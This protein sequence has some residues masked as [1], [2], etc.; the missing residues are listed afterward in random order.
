MLNQKDFLEARILIV[1]DRQANVLLL[2]SLL[3]D[4]GYLHLMSTQD[5]TEVCDLHQIHRFDLIV[6]DIQMPVMDGFEVMAALKKM[7]TDGDYTPILAMTVQSSH[8][9]KALASGA[10]DFIVKPFEL[11]EVKARIHNMLEVSLLYQKLKDS[12]AV[13]SS[14]ALHDILTKLPN[15]RLLM[16]RLVHAIEVS[17]LTHSHCALMF[18][19]ID[20][21]KQINDTLGHDVGDLL[22]QQVGDRLL[23]CVREGDSVARFGGDEF[24]VLLE[25]LSHDACEASE[26]AQ[27]IAQKMRVS[28]GKTFYLNGHTYDTSISIGVVIF[29]GDQEPIGAILKKADLAMYQAKLEGRN[30]VR[31]FDGAMQMELHSHDALTNDMHRGLELQEFMLFY[32]VQV[33]ELGVPIGAEALMRWKHPHRGLMV[34]A[35]FMP[36]AE[37]TCMILSLGQWVLETACQQLRAWAKNPKTENW[38]MAINVSDCQFAKSDFVTNVT[39]ALQ[40]TGANPHRLMLELTESILKNNVQDVIAKMNALK[41][42]GVRFCVD[43]FG[44]GLSSLAHLRQLPL[45]QLKIAPS[46][47]RKMLTDE[48][49]AVIVR[50]IIDLGHSL[51]LEVIAVA[52]ENAKQRERLADMGCTAFQ[53]D[54]FGS[55]QQAGDLVEIWMVKQVVELTGIA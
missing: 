53:G 49:D 5:P 14:F 19:D 35:R 15:R 47:V 48:I 3:R 1:D 51:G 16:Q 28:I 4:A 39:S 50:A 24:V 42:L 20:Y 29:S 2:E 34:A 33:N 54:Y 25:A 12:I 38:T 26:Q 41:V 11:M 17:E 40:K 32:Q 37:E 18:S 22:L 36:L 55:A 43:D 6:L 30:T 46:F 10:K 21:F 8:K 13:L 23:L 44:T 52:V 27:V 45:D 31:M 7:E 9:L